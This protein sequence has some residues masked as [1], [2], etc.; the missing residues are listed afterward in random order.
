MMYSNKITL[1]ALVSALS[2][3]IGASAMEE[4]VSLRESSAEL[5]QRIPQ[6]YEENE[7]MWSLDPRQYDPK[8]EQNGT[9]IK[10]S[11]R[12]FEDDRYYDDQKKD[13]NNCCL[14]MG[15]GLGFLFMGYNGFMQL[16]QKYSGN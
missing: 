2:L 9:N 13:G 7:Q 3:S 5:R 11:Q 16:Y 1:M 14:S 12:D 4:K 10:I 15:V 6:I 8:M